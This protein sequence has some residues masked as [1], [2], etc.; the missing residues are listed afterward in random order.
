MKP[1]A[2]TAVV[3]AACLLAPAPAAQA[4]WERVTSSSSRT[5]TGQVAAVRDPTGT[6]HVAWRSTT[7][8]YRHRLDHRQIAP[9][10]TLRPTTTITEDWVELSDP[11]ITASPEGL[12]VLFGGLRS[13]HPDELNTELN[14]ALSVD[15]GAGWTLQDGSIVAPGTGAADAPVA[16][17]AQADGVPLAAWASPRGT[18][19][20]RGVDAAVPASDL[21][22]SLGGTGTRPGVA[23]VGA[24]TVVAWYSRSGS[25]RG[26]YAQEIS[27]GGVP[28]GT[29]LPMP[30]TSGTRMPMEG[31]TPV[32]ARAGGK[33]F[34]AYAAGSG[35][36][37]RILLWQVGSSS[38][39]TIARAS[40]TSVA[41]VATDAA[42][43]VWVAWTSRS[44]GR[45]RVRARRSDAKVARFG[46]TIDAGRPSSGA[47]A[48][49]LDASAAGESLD[50][51]AGYRARGSSRVG[52]W[53]SRIA[54]D[55]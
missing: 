33:V 53:Y 50:V 52:T 25:A 30:G 55:D 34:V 21:Q 41:T 23:S 1:R 29:P 47:A 15:G 42:G 51:L 11:G 6:L 49:S 12:R 45:D 43:R 19:V 46:P 35:S 9:D 22:A 37:R 7:A 36:S 10:G 14:T 5:T 3:A 40:A 48:V 16:A 26:V 28:V 20:H 32:A 18:W 39:R 2:L 8:S 4:Q 31:R 13:S 27:P 24:R 17:V 54:E 44:R 38:A